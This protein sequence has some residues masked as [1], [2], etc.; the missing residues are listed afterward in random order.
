[1]RRQR[2]QVRSLVQH[3]RQHRSNQNHIPRHLNFKSVP[4]R[5]HAHLSHF[6]VLV[7][8]SFQSSEYTK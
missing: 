2:V 1:V 4:T 3:L 6:Y 5:W 7:E 8:T